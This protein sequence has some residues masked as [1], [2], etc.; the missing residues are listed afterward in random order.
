MNRSI[1]EE[2]FIIFETK[3]EFN[4]NKGTLIRFSLISSGLYIYI[5]FIRNVKVS[6]P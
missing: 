2:S 1:I 3:K 6:F 4:L 5:F